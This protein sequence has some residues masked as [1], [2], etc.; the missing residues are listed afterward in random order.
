MADG[1]WSAY[2]ARAIQCDTARVMVM[3]LFR[4]VRHPGSMAKRKLMGG[5]GVT[6]LD[7]RAMDNSLTQFPIDHETR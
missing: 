1:P 7:S 5:R 2:G 6:L 4:G 3:N